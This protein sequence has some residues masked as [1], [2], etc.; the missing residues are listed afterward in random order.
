MSLLPPIKKIRISEDFSTDQMADATSIQQSSSLELDDKSTNLFSRQIAAI[1]AETTAKLIKMKVLIYGLRGIGIETAKNLAIQGTGAITLIDQNI[2]EAKDIGLNFFLH[3]EDIGKPRAVVV[4]PRLRELNPLCAVSIAPVLDELVVSFHTAVVVT[5]PLPLQKL[6]DLDNFCRN[7]KIA[8]FYCFSGG[9]STSIFVDHGVDHII[10]DANGDKPVQKLVTGITP[11]DSNELLVRYEAPEGEQP[12]ALIS[13][14]FEITEVNGI[15][16]SI[17]STVFPVTHPDKDP[18]KTVRIPFNEANITP[19]VTGGLLTEKKVPFKYPMESLESKLKNPGNPF[20][21]PPTLVLTDLINFG[22]ETQ[23]HVA[24]IATHKFLAEKGHLPG[25]NSDVDANTI[26]EYAKS[27]VVSGEVNLPDFE[28]DE[29]QVLRYAR[30]AASELQPIVAFTGGVLAQEIVKCTGKFTPIPGFLH[31]SA[32]EALPNDAPSVADTLPRNSTYD[33]L[34]SIYGWNFVERLGSLKYFMVGCG[35]LGCEFMKN[36]ALNGI[37]CGPQGKLVVTD[38]DR[39]ELS[40]LSRQF[41]FREH[42]VGQPKSRA[43]SVMAKVMNSS[44]NVE[45]LEL[46]VGPKSEDVFDDEFWL[47]LDGVCNALDNMEARLY[48]DKQCVKYEKSLL[49][50]GTMGTSGNVDPI[51]PFKTRTYQDGGKA[52][53]GGGVPM[54]TLRNFPHLTDHCIEWSRDQFELLFTKLGKSCESF[55][56]DPE[57]FELK[58]KEKASSEPGSAFFDVRS[59]TSFV[60]VAASPSIGTAAQLAFD[61]FHFLF[62]DRILDLQ[63]AFPADARMIDKDGVDKGPFWGEKKRYPTPAVFNPDD[64]S[65]TSF[66]LSATCLF[67][68]AVGIIPPKH[69]NDNNW[70][71]DYRNKEWILGI[72]SYLNPP[73]YIQ[74]P[75]NKEGIEDA[76]ATTDNKGALN[77]MI[78][79]LLMELREAAKNIKS[80]K[81]FET[82]DF[83]KDDDLNFHI[84]FVTAAANLRCDNYAIKRT[85]FQACKVIAGKIIAAIATTTAAVCG[86]VILEL[87]KLL[88]EKDTDSFM[89]RA[90]GL[91]GF[92]YTSFTQEPPIKFSTKTKLV[93]PDPQE[94]LPGDAY[95][96]KGKIKE[97]FYTKVVTRAYPENHST[98]DKITVPG[99]LTLAQFSEWLAAEHKI[100]LVSWDFIYGHKSH[101]AVSTSVYPPKPI[102]NYSLLPSLE[103][104]IAQATGAIM[105]IP[106]AKPAQQYISLWRECKSKG[107]I[108]P[109]PTL[110]EDTITDSTT[111]AQILHR[112]ASIAESSEQKKVIDTRAISSLAKRKFFIIPGN[113]APLCRD[114]ESEE[115]IEH[116]CAFKILL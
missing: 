105:K 56:T 103:L 43:A 54:C 71:K 40:N 94:E 55:L 11:L 107:E 7:N 97:E 38:A 84:E 20:E 10:N 35:A 112:M 116:L 63:A 48:V 99:N 29:K 46:F 102:L 70:L 3:K 12:V 74:A 33:E 109:Q 14:F 50:S 88:L 42:N 4:Q 79:G 96:E 1:G 15:S 67:A 21:E 80:D 83:E 19:Y 91:A 32:P 23:Q 58:I 66:L 47:G 101:Q 44:F 78:E 76:T 52:A 100:K 18:V 60:K 17:N 37:C 104:T 59:V 69:E 61:L 2:T 111:L 16:A 62:R 45:A 8:F 26:L 39:I 106:A 95:D 98:W 82:A 92:Q 77:D 75:I 53:E 90:I 81:E 22:S 86:L 115:D 31:F 24:F 57:S 13:G 41:L 49:E 64:D 87:F 108:P 72:V 28:V 25:V 27:V 93:P 113:E 5:L 30:H 6:V 9:V 51:C 114:I 110:S 68:V 73:P 36:F 89:N 85:D 34:A 65:H